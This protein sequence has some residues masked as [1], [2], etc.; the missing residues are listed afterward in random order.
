MRTWIV[1]AMAHHPADLADR[2]TLEDRFDLRCRKI[3]PLEALETPVKLSPDYT[4]SLFVDDKIEAMG[5][6]FRVDDETASP[7]LLTSDSIETAPRTLMRLFR[8]YLDNSGF[9]YF[10]NYVP[11]ANV[12]SQ[13]L[14]RHLGFSL[15]WPTSFG[16]EPYLTFVRR[17]PA[18]THATP[19]V[20][21]A[22][23]DSDRPP[24]G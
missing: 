2:L 13:R 19:I 16:G 20:D 4:F 23:T 12:K 8:L 11:L 24:P 7:W 21:A 22:L 15:G 5:G 9:R 17:H 10:Y 18:K 3:E 1:R 14:I 6:Y